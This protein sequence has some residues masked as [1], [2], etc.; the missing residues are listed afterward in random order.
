MRFLRLRCNLRQLIWVHLFVLANDLSSLMKILE[1][2]PKVCLSSFVA[3]PVT[4]LLRRPN[5]VLQFI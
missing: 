1:G 2:R 5:K 3:L 4:E